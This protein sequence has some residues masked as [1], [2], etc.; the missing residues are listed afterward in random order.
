[1]RLAVPRLLA[2]LLSMRDVSRNS[3][4]AAD[5]SSR[6]GGAIRVL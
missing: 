5:G 4:P 2:V 1:L 3:I 6:R